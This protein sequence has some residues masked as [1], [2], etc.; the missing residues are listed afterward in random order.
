MQ[1]LQARE[2]RRK[3]EERRH[4]ALE[5][6]RKMR[7]DWNRRG[8]SRPISRHATPD[9]R[10]SVDTRRQRR[11]KGSESR[12]R[13]RTSVEKGGSREKRSKNTASEESGK[14]RRSGGSRHSRRSSKHSSRS[15]RP[16]RRGESKSREK[17][18]SEVKK[19]STEQIAQGRQT[20]QRYVQSAEGG[21][22]PQ[23][24]PQSAEGGAEPQ[25]YPQSA[26]GGAESQ[27]YPQSAEGGSGPQS[28]SR[29]VKSKSNLL[30]DAEVKS[31]LGPHPNADLQ[32]LTAEQLGEEIAVKII[33]AMGVSE[34][35]AQ[36]AVSDFQQGYVPERVDLK[37]IPLPPEP[38]LPPQSAPSTP[39]RKVVLKPE[40][41]AT[42]GYPGFD[43]TRS[44]GLAQGGS[45][46]TPSITPSGP[47]TAVVQPVPMDTGSQRGTASVPQTPTTSAS[48]SGWGVPR[49]E[50]PFQPQASTGWRSGGWGMPNFPRGAPQKPMV[51]IEIPSDM[52]ITKPGTVPQTERSRGLY[53]ESR[54]W[55]EVSELVMKIMEKL[56]K[57]PSLLPDP[58]HLREEIFHVLETVKEWR[59]QEVLPADLLYFEEWI[60][61]LFNSV[62]PYKEVT[63]LIASVDDVS[64]NHISD[65]RV[66]YLDNGAECPRFMNGDPNPQFLDQINDRLQYMILSSRFSDEIPINHPDFPYTEEQKHFTGVEM[67][68]KD[69]VMC[70]MNRLS[71]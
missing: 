10:K 61:G 32:H 7:E 68:G 46:F 26:E 19:I 67:T 57:K 63:R 35:N 47:P 56:V 17:P 15:R 23:L 40:T 38:P 42:P 13:K 71:G 58:P 39:H 48:S 54:N 53:D 45:I 2:N 34:H 44:I 3:E 28:Q 6:Q 66:A 30:S 16:E 41:T 24:Y 25:M 29:S 21:A 70:S 22:E 31:R 11:S 8:S 36:K 4:D 55:K 5:H 43:H 20:M 59:D 37:T 49:G 9:K 65:Y 51:P 64:N 18:R 33:R 12:S 62:L 27:M 50:P 1:D 60:Y 52:G 69:L 14:E